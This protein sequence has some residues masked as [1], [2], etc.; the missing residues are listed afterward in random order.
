MTTKEQCQ[1]CN[2]DKRMPFIESTPTWQLFDYEIQQNRS[3]CAFAWGIY[4]W[5]APEPGAEVQFEPFVGQF[6]GYATI[7]GDV[8]V[9]S[10]WK[11][12]D[13]AYGLDSADDAKEHLEHLPKWDKTK[14]YTKIFD[15]ND[16]ELYNCETGERVPESIAIPI[17]LELKFTERTMWSE[18]E[19]IIK[20]KG[21][22]PGED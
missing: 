1:R 20:R 21:E 16:S 10:S 2:M 9:L 13:S 3:G 22:T 5:E 12:H 15:F 18:I 8:L 14:Y 4:S 17:M 6:T 19:E 7:K 11:V